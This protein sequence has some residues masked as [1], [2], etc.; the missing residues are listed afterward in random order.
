MLK[1]FERFLVFLGEN[2]IV[3]YTGLILPSLFFIIFSV[4]IPEFF[5]LIWYVFLGMVAAA[6]YRNK[7]DNIGWSIYPIFIISIIILYKVSYFLGEWA[8]KLIHH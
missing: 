4:K 8:D 7:K 3:I 1:F 2:R 6:R 5:L